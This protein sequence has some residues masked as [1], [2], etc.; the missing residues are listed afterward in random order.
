MNVDYTKA[1]AYEGCNDTDAV[2][3]SCPNFPHCKCGLH[4]DAGVHKTTSHGWVGVDL[5]G[6][7]ATY[8][9]WKGA[10]HIGEPISAMVDVVKYFIGVGREVRI[11]TARVSG[12]DR[13]GVP[14]ERTIQLIEEW[15][16]RHIG[17]RLPVTCVKDYGMIVLFD[18]RVV[19]VETNTGR[20]LGGTY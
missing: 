15:C 7:L 18:D 16:E 5:D 2:G 6:T 3:A 17:V 11:M 12:D 14:R 19:A 13:Q 20:I 1:H 9:G 8:D 10:E 4:R